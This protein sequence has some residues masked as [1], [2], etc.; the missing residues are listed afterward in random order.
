[1]TWQQL[2]CQTRAEHQEAIST[3]LEDNGAVSVTLQDAA[4]Q[5]LLEPLPGETPIWDELLV[6]GLFP[7]SQDLTGVM[8]LL[9]AQRD[10]WAISQLQ[11]EALED[12]PGCANGWTSFSRCC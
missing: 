11:L 4:D 7:A 12:R 5:P 6:T 10:A 3:W 2:T 9:E 1:M 8:L